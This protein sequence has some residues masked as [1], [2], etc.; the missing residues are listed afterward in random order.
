M[1]STGARPTINGLAIL[2]GI[3]GS[4]LLWSGLRNRSIEETLRRAIR[5][6]TIDTAPSQFGRSAPLGPSADPGGPTPA[7]GTE[8]GRAVA[9]TAAGYVGVPYI[10]GGETPDGWD[11]SGFVTWVL[12]KVHGIDLPNDNHTVAAQ[13]YVWRGARTVPRSSCA[14]GDL[15]CWPTH[16]GIALSRDELVH[17]PGL[18]QSTRRQKIW[19]GATIRRP[20]AYGGT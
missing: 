6:Q 3:A 10:W 14:P 19:A 15:V 4:V 16:I 9:S 7:G 8:F 5:G 1:A 12:H 2:A 18:F 20:V 17:A 11:C 13:F